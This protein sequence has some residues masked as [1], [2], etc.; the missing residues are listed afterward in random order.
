MNGFEIAVHQDANSKIGSTVDAAMAEDFLVK[1][2]RNRFDVRGHSGT[3]P[4]VIDKY[5]RNSKGLPLQV[6]LNQRSGLKVWS[7]RDREYVAD[8]RAANLELKFVFSID[9]AMK[10]VA[11]VAL[12]AGYF[13]YGELFRTNVK[14]SDFRA[15]MNFESSDSKRH[16]GIEARI[17][18]RFSESANE[19]IRIFRGL[20]RASEP[21]SLVGFAHS[22][23]RFGV[24][25]GILGD[26]IGMIHVPA[27]M[28]DFPTTGEHDMGHVIQLQRPGLIR[29]SMRHT[30]ESFVRWIEG[31]KVKDSG[32]SR[33]S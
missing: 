9:T 14:H 33:R 15:I 25:V 1:M 31:S 29:H 19:D 5:A 13:T 7:P 32:E 21:Y 18:D 8:E 16:E 30:L 22:R 12:S 23:D 17:D 27:K 28:D 20:C 2:K 11:K 26:Y 3:E 6:A 10:F 24:F 4:V